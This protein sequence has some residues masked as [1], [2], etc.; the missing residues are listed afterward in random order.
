MICEKCNKMHNGSY[1]SGRF[2]SRSCANSRNWTSVDIAKKSK[3]AKQSTKVRNANIKRNAKRWENYVGS[4]PYTKL[5][6]PIACPICHKSF[7]PRYHTTYC[8]RLCFI[9]DVGG[10][11]RKKA[12]GGLRHGSGRGKSGWYKDMWCDSTYE[13]AY[14]I[15]HID[16]NI[17]IYRNREYWTYIDPNRYNKTFKYY[18]DFVVNNT[19]IEIKGYKSTLDNTKIESVTK[20]I[21][22]LYK[23]QLSGI[24][25]YIKAKYNIPIT[26]LWELYT[27][28]TPI[29][30]RCK[31]CTK[32]F[33]NFKTTATFCSRQCCG[34]CGGRQQQY[35]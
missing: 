8:S 10:K 34:K 18:P 25:Q 31:C 27:D 11:Y 28:R 6:T 30:H 17:P 7:Y 2:C 16:Y 24:F 35:S 1:G 32:I 26:R 21:K 22:I 4:K 12:P 20:P 15:Y 13:L 23:E 5:K 3:S 19:L 9:D 14:V 29:K 33:Y